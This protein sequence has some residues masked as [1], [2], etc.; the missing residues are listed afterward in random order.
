MKKNYC[1]GLFLL[2][3]SSSV[4]AQKKSDEKD[5]IK[6]MC[7]CYEVNFEYSETF[8]PSKDYEYHDRYS[9]S[10]LEWIF[11]DEES[12]DKIVIQHL[13][14]INDSTIIKHWR[15]D[16]L[17]ENKDLLV[18][19]KN[20]EWKKQEVPKDHLK[21]SWTQKVYQVDDS[22]RY[23]GYAHWVNI[24]GK[25][26]WESQVSA[27][28]PRRE[29]TKRSDYNVMLRTNK[30]KLMDYGHLHELDNAKVLRTEAGDS[31]IVLE[32]GH[33]TYKKVDDSRCNPAE[34]WW[35]SNRPYWVDVREVWNEKISEADF[36][37]IKN[38]VGNKKLWQELFALANE[39]EGLETYSSEE[40]KV[41]VSKIIDSYLSN[42]PSSW[43][44][45]SNDY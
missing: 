19:E 36:I 40:V 3:L 25:T 27:P 21:N 33:N 23:N 31:L 42:S 15:E 34:K 2:L 8:S 1:L 14:I 16:W 24:D 32:K 38:K 28:L 20:L 10:G 17:Y 29:Y 4:L 30:H 13:L 39:Y 44:S 45:A 43:E 7:G 6:D 12:S 41:K 9:A 37:N 11:V 35:T 26:Y 5:F 22:P 18:Y